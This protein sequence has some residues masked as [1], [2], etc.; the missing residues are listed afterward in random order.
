MNGIANNPIDYFRTLF[1]EAGRHKGIKEPGVVNLATASRDGMPSNRMVLLKDFDEDGFVFYTNLH[2]HKGQHLDENPFASMCF[3]WEPLS[4]Q[5]RIEGYVVAV[6]DAE[7]DAYFASRPLKSRIGAWASRQ[8]QPLDHP[9]TLLKA[10]A[11]HT[12]RFAMQDV[13]RPDFWSGFRLVPCYMEFWQKG[14]YR[15]HERVCYVRDEPGQWQSQL[16]YP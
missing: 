6:D 5:V 1:D 15:V 10:I 11:R 13:P 9:K 14:D 3:Y 4:K 7:A 2:S 8:S 12:A 16:L